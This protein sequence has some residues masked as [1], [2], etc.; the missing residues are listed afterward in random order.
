MS[1]RSVLA[2][3]AVATLAPGRPAQA[4]EPEVRKLPVRLQVRAGAHDRHETP[5]EVS[6]AGVELPA[7]GMALVELVDGQAKPASSQLETQ[8]GEPARLAWLLSGRTPAGAM[9]QFE[10]RA[11]APASPPAVFVESSDEAV[12]VRV[13]E[14]PVLRYR[15]ARV[16]PPPGVD[17]N[18]GRSAFMHPVRSPSGQIVTDAFPPD[19]LHQ[20]GVWLAYPKARFR[21]REA[22][23]WELARGQGTVR[24]VGIGQAQGGPVFGRF[25]AQHEHVLF[26][27]GQ[28]TVALHESW[29]VRVWSLGGDGDSPF[30]VDVESTQTCASADP[31]EVLQYHY[32]GMAIRGGRDWRGE[33]CRFLTSNGHPRD[34]GNHTAVRWCDMA[35]ACNGLTAGIALLSHPENLRHPEVVRIHPEMPYFCFTA[36]FSGD[37]KIE[38]NRP[39]VVRY[40]LVVHDGAADAARL[41]RLWTDFAEPVT[42]ELSPADGG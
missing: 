13:G 26:D 10:L 37:W 31:L 20:D 5:V 8:G 39:R 7:E 12:D 11:G 1:W 23:F 3:I 28:E 40:R 42:V 15:V 27:G 33:Q 14:R 25:T 4:S 41:D 30:V 6:L 24:C 38:P 18:Y 17:A 32:G 22:N 21:G 34:A 36:A 9:R 35:G 16:E 19:H 29:R 2:C